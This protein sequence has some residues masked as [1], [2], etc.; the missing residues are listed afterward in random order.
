[1]EI[2]I[3]LILKQKTLCVIKL[4]YKEAQTY[5]SLEKL[6]LILHQIHF[7]PKEKQKSKLKNIISLMR[8]RHIA[9]KKLK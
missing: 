9:S 7:S 4:T 5:L 3:L 2:S 8:K 1:M 6:K